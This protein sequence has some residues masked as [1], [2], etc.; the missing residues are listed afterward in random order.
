MKDWHQEMTEKVSLYRHR[1]EKDS[2]P[3]N[4]VYCY[5]CERTLDEVSTVTRI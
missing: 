3:K 1:N 4:L 2:F 5:E